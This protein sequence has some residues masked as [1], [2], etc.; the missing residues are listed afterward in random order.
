MYLINY[1]RISDIF[2]KRLYFTPTKNHIR[3][4]CMSAYTERSDNIILKLL[5][6]HM[7]FT[8]VICGYVGRRNTILEDLSVGDYIQYS[9]KI[10][11]PTLLFINHFFF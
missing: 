6:L 7:F 1:E 11:S 3:W 4:V 5:Q 2:H 9:V 10:F 8:Y